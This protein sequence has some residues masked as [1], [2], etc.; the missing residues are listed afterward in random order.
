MRRLGAAAVPTAHARFTGTWLVALIVAGAG[1]AII[2]STGSPALLAAI[3]MLLCGWSLAAIM[4]RANQYAVAFNL[5]IATLLPDVLGNVLPSQ[6]VLILLAANVGVLVATGIRGPVRREDAGLAIL[7]A[8]VL[9]P[10]VVGGSL[11][12]LPGALGAVVIFYAM[13]R[14][15][16]SLPSFVAVLLLVGAVHGAVAIAQ[17]VPSLSSLIPFRPILNGLPFVS[18]RATGLFNNPNTLGA[19]EAVVLVTAIRVGS[20]RWTLPLIALCAVGLVLSASREGVFGL[21]VGLSLLGIR[22]PRQMVVWAIGFIIVGG[23]VL[24]A[25]PSLFTIL[26]PG[27][28]GTDADLLRR[29]E[30]WR[31]ATNLIG[32][33]P[34][35]GYG[36]S[37]LGVVVTDNAYLSW[38]LAG[39]IAGFALWIVGSCVATPRRLAPVLAAMFAISLL[40]NAFSGPSY[41]VFLSA[42]GAVVAESARQRLRVPGAAGAG[43]AQLNR[44]LPTGS[45][46]R[47]GDES[48]TAVAD[49][50]R[51]AGRGASTG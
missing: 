32:T 24:W 42:C 2:G 7:L 15:C 27:G 4:H 19:L 9:W 31:A 44:P 20:R 12:T 34:F 45:L 10:Y 41:A 3:A 11:D 38:L 29:F 49:S 16:G 25:F 22:R 43:V 51:Q 28:Y 36:A 50:L 40:G 14:L 39:G 23:I 48:S 33:S 26:D 6:Q 47:Q 13:G 1:G 8:A 21:I 5:A 30:M 35:Y 46:A 17:S 37:V 18:S